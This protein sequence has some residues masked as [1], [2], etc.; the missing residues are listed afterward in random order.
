MGRILSHIT[1][2]LYNASS[3]DTLLKRALLLFSLF[4]PM[5]ALRGM[6]GTWVYVGAVVA[7]TVF[8]IWYVEQR[9]ESANRLETVLT[10]FV[11]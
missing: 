1:P 8:H 4:G 10:Y 7:L 9:D 3:H 2:P 6:L 5:F 11:V